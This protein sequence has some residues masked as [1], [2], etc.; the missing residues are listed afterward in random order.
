MDGLH[1]K[2]TMWIT[3]FTPFPMPYEYIFPY[4]LILPDGSRPFDL[5]E[6]YFVG[7]IKD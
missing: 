7:E 2:G 1:F 6:A 3:T 4:D 5:P